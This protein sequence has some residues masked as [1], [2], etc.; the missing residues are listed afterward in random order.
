[1]VVHYQPIVSLATGRITGC[2]ALLRWN[3]PERGLMQPDEFIPLA[4]ETGLIVPIGAWAL[5]TACKQ[6]QSWLEQGMPP[7]DLAVNFSARQFKQ[8]TLAERIARPLTD[9]GFDPRRLQLELTES[10]LM[11]ATELATTTLRE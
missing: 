8:R 1:L 5:E 11:E 4:E 9:S 10:L 7:M 6:M 2:E 3:H